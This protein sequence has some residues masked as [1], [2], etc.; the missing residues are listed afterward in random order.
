METD[1]DRLS[2]Y[3]DGMRRQRAGDSEDGRNVSSSGY[4]RPT[5][6]SS[7][8]SSDTDR[9]RTGG[10]EGGRNVSSSGYIRPTGV[11]SSG[12]SDADRRRAINAY[13][14]G[15]IADSSLLTSSEIGSTGPRQS[16]QY[17]KIHR[18]VDWHAKA[19]TSS[20]T[21]SSNNIFP[22]ALIVVDGNVTSLNPTILNVKRGKVNVR[23]EQFNGAV[24]SGRDSIVAD[25][26]KEPSGS[27]AVAVDHAIDNI[28]HD[29]Y[30]SG[31]TIPPGIVDKT[32]TYHSYKEAEFGMH[33]SAG[34]AGAS[35]KASYESSSNSCRSISIRDFCQKYYTVKADLPDGDYSQLFGDDVTVDMLRR[36]IQNN[37][38]LFVDSVTYGR[39][40]YYCS[41]I[42]T[43]SSSMLATAEAAYSTYFSADSKWKKSSQDIRFKSWFVLDGGNIAGTSA[44]YE[45]VPGTNLMASNDGQE[46]G[47]QTTLDRIIAYQD[48]MK[49]RVN[50]YVQSGIS[51]DRNTQGVILSYTTSF[52]SNNLVAAQFGNTGSYIEET[53]IP[54]HPVQILFQN[55]RERPRYIS[56][57]WTEYTVDDYGNIWES[58]VEY[59]KTHVG[60]KRGLSIEVTRNTYQ[61]KN[62]NIKVWEGDSVNIVSGGNILL[63]ADNN[64]Y[65]S[66]EVYYVVYWNRSMKAEL[67][68]KAHWDAHVG[69]EVDLG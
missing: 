2:R 36:K 51:I 56:A 19:K 34:Y 67:L 13:I 9:Q 17:L 47:Q 65:P 25:A 60:G 40:A 48:E 52:M 21:T 69:M 64:Y 49:R 3:I 35:L 41:E 43:H 37:A 33:A 7:S 46:D 44:F 61:V 31:V 18:R 24:I 12:G 1:D 55:R 6:V 20:V 28:L 26:S 32:E 50:N 22:G 8:G 15:L 68:D 4:V 45:G 63:D 39:R 30:N 59:P 5:L 23:V 58:Q 54:I 66:E 10:S 16:G 11:Y 27:M 38:L 14:S 29:F 53:V 57:S 62:I 42:E